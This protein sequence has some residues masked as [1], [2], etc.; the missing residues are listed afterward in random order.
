MAADTKAQIRVAI[1]G[2]GLAGASMANALY[3]LPHIDVHIYEA[4][5][6]FSERGA[7]VGLA[8]NALVAL[9]DLIPNSQEVV[10][11][12]AGGVKMNSARIMTVK[13]PSRIGCSMLIAA[14]IR[15]QGWHACFRPG[16]LQL[17]TG[18]ASRCSTKSPAGASAN[19]YPAC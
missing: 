14:G 11:D 4:A 12:R 18:I 5:P 17:R 19:S 6:Q 16:R 3:K 9:E 2:G 1:V 13:V 7:A 10:L 15:A 8:T